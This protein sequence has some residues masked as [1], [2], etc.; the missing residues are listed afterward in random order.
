[1]KESQ[2]WCVM[3]FREPDYWSNN[4]E[5][6]EEGGGAG[7]N[8]GR[9]RKGGC[10]L[11]QWGEVG[12]RLCLGPRGTIGILLGGVG[13]QGSRGELVSGCR[14]LWS[15]CWLVQLPPYTHLHLSLSLSLSCPPSHGHTNC[16]IF[17]LFASGLRLPSITVW[18]SAADV[19]G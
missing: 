6:E 19:D 12:G 4:A 1:M 11:G 18:L 14:R 3:K 16:V 10:V 7:C 13:V 5:W 9:W 17:F 8:G 15:L 2:S